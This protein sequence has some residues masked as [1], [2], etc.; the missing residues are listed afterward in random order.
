[1]SIACVFIGDVRVWACVS[2][3]LVVAGVGVA[4]SD[5]ADVY[6]SMLEV[7]GALFALISAVFLILLLVM[8][9][10]D[11]KTSPA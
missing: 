3:L 8:G 5:R 11:S 6:R 10:G 1:M 4:D 2:G 9:G 7:I